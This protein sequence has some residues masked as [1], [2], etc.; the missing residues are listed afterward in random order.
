V[1]CVAQIDAPNVGADPKA[2]ETAVEYYDVAGEQYFVT[3][4]PTEIAAL[5]AGLFDG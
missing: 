3:A 4:N 1:K 2:L 5:D